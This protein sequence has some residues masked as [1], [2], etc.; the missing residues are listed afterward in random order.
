MGIMISFTVITRKYIQRKIP[1]KSFIGT[2][3]SAHR[4]SAGEENSRRNLPP[5]PGKCSFSCY[6]LLPFL[7]LTSQYYYLSHGLLLLSSSDPSAQS[8]SFTRTTVAAAIIKS[9]A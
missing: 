7:F 4:R 3:V 1:V 6:F 9:P 8:V 2:G 5:V